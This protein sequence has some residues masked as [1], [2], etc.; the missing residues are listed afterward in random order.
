MEFSPGGISP[1]KVAVYIRWSTDDQGEGTT[2]ETQL[3]R[4]K[5][6]LISQG[7]RFHDRLVYID[8]G[9]SGGTLD[10][11]ALSRLRADVANGLVDC[12][13]VY[14]I[15]RLSRSVID[16]V[17]LVLREW[18]GRCYVKSTSEDVNT[19]TPA[20][21]M[22]FYI[23]ISF[24]EYER[25]VI[26][27]R[28]M[29]GKIKRAEQGL[30]PGFRPPF[31]YTRGESAGAFRVVAH[32]ASV[33]R[34]IFGLYVQGN[35]PSQIGELLNMEQT[36]RRGAL[37]NPLMIR[38][39]LTNPTYVGRLEYGKTQ[40][41][42]KDQ[43]ER[44]GLRHV[45]R[46]A[47]PR[48][49][50]VEEAVEPI[51]DRG[52]WEAV[53]TLLRARSTRDARRARPTYSDYLL[54][55]LVVCRCGAPVN[56]KTVG[57]HQYY[58]CA[59][60]KSRGRSVCDAGHIPVSPVDMEMERRVRTLLSSAGGEPILQA[61][62]E[63]LAERVREIQGGLAECRAELQAGA[64]RGR[65]V[66][67]DYRSGELPARLYATEL[68]ALSQHLAGVGARAEHLERDLA[69]VEAA[70]RNRASLEAA[71]DGTDIWAALN[72][73]ERRQL[74][75]KLTAGVTLHRAVGSG[76]PPV[77]EIVWIRL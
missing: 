24:A 6:F 71:L 67:Q 50:V 38:R 66:G 75:Q 28:T 47:R 5:H 29:N 61:L 9:Y 19:L 42:T 32:E 36:L 63:G 27:E 37:W 76:D 12:A 8:D 16:I 4:C 68:E 25:N 33:V 72:V 26:R 15:D 2:L 11:P 1:D 59:H 7:W 39:V 23:L 45:I 57:R 53:Q 60:R 20:G 62:R 51:V 18:E 34:R 48:F 73:P 43:R 35:G 41:T 10:R 17:E 44:Q 55:G 69:E 54:S 40:R 22:F 77:L 30:N 3:E 21:K 64:E 56:G 46:Y 49:A 70:R 58:Y 74:L 14:R 13:V 52:T 65:R 31:G